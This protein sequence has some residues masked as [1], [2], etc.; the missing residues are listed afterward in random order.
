MEWPTQPRNLFYL[1]PLKTAL[2]MQK[3]TVTLPFFFFLQKLYKKACLKSQNYAHTNT[4]TRA[5][6]HTSGSKN[7]RYIV[8]K[9]QGEAGQRRYGDLSS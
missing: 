9:A 1:F 2:K 7:L 8:E 5:H 3:I 6:T 4:D